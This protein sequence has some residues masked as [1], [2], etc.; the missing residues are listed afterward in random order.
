M[1]LSDTVKASSPRQI[2]SVREASEE[3]GVSERTIYRMIRSG[4]LVRE[5]RRVGNVNNVSVSI[6]HNDT[7]EIKVSESNVSKMS[8]MSDTMSGSSLEIL[9]TS[10]IEKDTQIEQLLAQQRELNQTIQRLQEQMF[11]LA[12]LV[13]SQNTAASIRS[14]ESPVTQER[15]KGADWRRWL[16][17]FRPSEEKNQKK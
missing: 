4:K 16:S 5:K 17:L 11:E 2:S 15:E 12:R 13:L 3:L 6:C 1:N 9:K 14:A 10:L 8:I 7:N